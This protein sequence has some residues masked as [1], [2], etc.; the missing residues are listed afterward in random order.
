MSRILK[1]LGLSSLSVVLSCFILIHPAQA[2]R[3]EFKT[4]PQPLKPHT[5]CAL[6]M[7]AF[8]VPVPRGNLQ[9]QLA[10]GGVRLSI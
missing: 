2:E 8:A 10:C 1:P 3:L 7:Q 6:K 9:R 4:T 5:A